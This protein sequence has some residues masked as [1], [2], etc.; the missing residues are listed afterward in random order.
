MNVPALMSIALPRAVSPAMSPGL[1]HIVHALVEPVSQGLVVAP[2]RW[3]EVERAEAV[4][5]LPKYEELCRPPIDRGLIEVWLSRL[6]DMGVRKAPEGAAWDGYVEGVALLCGDLP[7]VVWTEEPLRAALGKFTWWPSPAELNGQLRPIGDRRKRELAALRTVAAMPEPQQ[8]VPPAQ[9]S[10]PELPMEEFAASLKLKYGFQMQGYDPA[11]AP[12]ETI[13]QRATAPEPPAANTKR[14]S[15]VE[16]RTRMSVGEHGAELRA[17][18][19]KMAASPR[20]E[21]A[22]QGRIALE[23]MDRAAAAI[24]DGS[25]R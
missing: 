6:A 4:R 5:I 12:S 20:P 24:R 25:P 3:G 8:P 1:D 21:V 19:E 17:S 22:E 23:L 14:L 15:S 9:S 10:E 2:P 13:E 16:L 7:A 18:Y 11:P